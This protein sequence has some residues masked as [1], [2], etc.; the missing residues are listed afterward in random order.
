MAEV[1]LTER[2]RSLWLIVKASNDRDEETRRN[3][4]L[5]V[6]PTLTADEIYLATMVVALF[7]F[8]NTFVDLHG[9]NELSAE[10][11]AASGVRLSSAG[12]TPPPR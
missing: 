5:R 1:D 6:A 10:G 12:Y 3:V 11:Y 8:Y 2:E 9:V 7:N 4:M